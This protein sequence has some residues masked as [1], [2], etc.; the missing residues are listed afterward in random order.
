MVLS[1]LGSILRL[2][3]GVYLMTQLSEASGLGDVLVTFFFTGVGGGLFNAPNTSQLMGAASQE[4]LGSVSALATTIRQIAFSCAL[5]VAEVIFSAR[6]AHHRAQVLDESLAPEL[7]ARMALFDGFS[8][9]MLLA[10][11]LCLL[12]IIVYALIRKPRRRVE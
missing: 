1:R 10:T 6:S 5:V 4:Q 11:I 7:V 9:T 3:V 12:G 8:D 2:F